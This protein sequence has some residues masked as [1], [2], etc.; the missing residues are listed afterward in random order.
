MPHI[1]YW[2]EEW[3]VL[4]QMFA[5]F[6]TEVFLDVFLERYDAEEVDILAKHMTL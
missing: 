3:K 1:L 4:Y 5:T 6:L 2:S